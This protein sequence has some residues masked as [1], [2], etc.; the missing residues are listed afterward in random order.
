MEEAAEYEEPNAE[1]WKKEPHEQTG[2]HEMIKWAKAPPFFPDAKSGPT[3]SRSR[4]KKTKDK[5][6]KEEVSE[7][8]TEEQILGLI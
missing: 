4:R 8:L 7:M 1:L 5:V 3:E 6:S 2:K